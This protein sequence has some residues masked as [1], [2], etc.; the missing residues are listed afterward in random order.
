MKILY[1]DI[2]LVQNASC[3]H[4]LDIV[5]IELYLKYGMLGI[6]FLAY[7][8]RRHSHHIASILKRFY[9]AQSF[10]DA[11]TWNLTIEV[12]SIRFEHLEQLLT[13]SD[14]ISHINCSKG[15]MVL[16]SQNQ[17]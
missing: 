7:L 5:A 12:D 8:H 13:S 6:F 14:P 2:K 11:L 1:K 15:H 4:E 16:N 3:I 17:A 9:K 10:N